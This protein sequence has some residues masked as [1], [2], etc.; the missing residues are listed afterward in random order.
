MFVDRGAEYAW[1]IIPPPTRCRV[2]RHPPELAV[3]GPHGRRGATVTMG[4]RLSCYLV[5]LRDGSAFLSVSSEHP[6]QVVEMIMT[7][8]PQ[9]AA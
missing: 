7:A 4:S 9:E 1:P 2:D 8:P 3:T 6:E 5:S